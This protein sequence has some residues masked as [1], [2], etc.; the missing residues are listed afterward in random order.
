MITTVESILA[1]ST[2]IITTILLSST[3]TLVGISVY[4]QQP[5][6]GS[7]WALL[8]S[9]QYF[10]NCP[11]FCTQSTFT[12]LSIAASSGKIAKAKYISIKIITIIN[13]KFGLCSF[14]V[15]SIV[16]SQTSGNEGDG[17]S[18]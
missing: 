16:V 12:A 17:K 9:E 7:R 15:D 18:K 1:N 3:I 8:K 5:A 10:L 6:V 11:Q 13:S 4:H 14:E 2:G